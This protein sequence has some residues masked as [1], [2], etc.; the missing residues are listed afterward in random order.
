MA[1]VAFDRGVKAAERYGLDGPVEVW[2]GIRD[3]IH[4]Q[5]CDAGFDTKRNSLCS[6][7]TAPSSTPACS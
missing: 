7:T 2:R 1:W 6:T 3:E 4:A 5:V